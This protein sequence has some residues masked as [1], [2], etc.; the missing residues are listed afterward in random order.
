MT[1]WKSARSGRNARASCAHVSLR[2]Y[3]ALYTA[4]CPRLA[5]RAA[6]PLERLFAGNAYF[7]NKQT[8]KNPDAFTILS[9]G[10]APQI[11]WIGCADSRIP[12]IIVCHC[13]PGDMFVHRNIA[14]T[15]HPDDDSAAS[16]VEYAVAHLKVDK[17]VVCGHTKCGG[18]MASLT[19]LDLGETL[20]R[21]LQPLRG[22]AQTPDQSLKECS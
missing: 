6:D 8:T 10:Q 1:K 12:E 5:D 16:V 15:I 4:L 18:A 20:N 3:N 22:Y 11:L 7:A 17:V 9:Q 2:L 14:N 21:W 19:D 13:K